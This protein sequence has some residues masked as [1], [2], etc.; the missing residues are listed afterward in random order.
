MKS[1]AVLIALAAAVAAGPALAAPAL[2]VPA[3][4]WGQG[5]E[6]GM[7]NTMGPASWARCAPY[8]SQPGAKVY[9]LSHPRGPAMPQS[10]FAGKMT[11]QY[12]PTRGLPHTAQAFNGDSL[13]GS[14]GSQGTRM[15]A[16]GLFGYLEA[17][18]DGKGDYPTADVRYYGG[19]RQE[20]VKPTPTSPLLKLGIDKV[21]PIVTS[22]VL[23]DA[24][25]YLGKGE[26]LKAGVAIS[27]ADIEGML[28]AQGLA[29]R[30]LLPGD[31]LFIYTGWEDH[32]ADPDAGK[33]YYA[34]DPG[35]SYEAAKYLASKAIVLVSLDNPFTDAVIGH[36]KPAVGNPPDLP[37]A[38]HHHN[39]TQ[40]GV[41]QVQNGRFAEMAKDKVWLSCALVLPLREQGS[42]GSAVR[43]VAIGAPARTKP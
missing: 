9:E 34:G 40:A 42:T 16:L 28:K 12:G 35:L 41:Y 6:V 7:G 43:P 32:W 8:L 15:N 17:P 30:G 19:H 33:V 4:A 37:W 22:A 39:L 13:A 20:E 24:R 31:A 3:P 38:V 5:D 25:A 27:V 29:K 36:D 2:S 18:W 10:G 21:P 14:Q 23:L 26:P 11:Y 1:A